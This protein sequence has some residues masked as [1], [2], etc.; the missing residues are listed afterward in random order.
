MKESTLEE[1]KL[2]LEWSRESLE[3]IENAR[4]EECDDEHFRRIY[5]GLSRII[6]ACFESFEFIL[7]EEGVQVSPV[8]SAKVSRTRSRR[9]KDA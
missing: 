3:F 4:R 6:R 7:K 1:V 8:K 9:V 2:K 5:D